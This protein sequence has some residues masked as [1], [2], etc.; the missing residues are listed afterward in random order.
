MKK[1]NIVAITV[2]FVAIADVENMFTKGQRYYTL[3]EHDL[4][5]MDDGKGEIVGGY[6]RDD[7]DNLAPV[8]FPS[9]SYFGGER[10]VIRNEKTYDK[11]AVKRKIKRYRKML[12]RAFYRVATNNGWHDSK[13]SPWGF[14]HKP[15]QLHNCKEW[16]RMMAEPF[17]DA[18]GKLQL[19]TILT[20]ELESCK[21]WQVDQAL[22]DYVAEE[23]VNAACW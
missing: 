7:S 14:S 16:A 18:D 2:S 23:E 11:E 6:V 13:V 12:I 10:L 19:H 9:S 15:G 17:F 4:I 5:R 20:D 3:E 21:P 1:S 8:H 22:F